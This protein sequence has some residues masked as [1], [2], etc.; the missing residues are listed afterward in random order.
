MRGPTKFGAGRLRLP[1][2]RFGA[3]VRCR[4]T[5][6]KTRIMAALKRYKG[7]VALTARRLKIDELDLYD[8]INLLGIGIEYARQL[9]QQHRERF[10]LP[11]RM[12][13]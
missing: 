11:P 7:N 3:L 6:A 8:Y 2:K 9:R 12:D 10:R 1:A 4:P 5:T 13:E